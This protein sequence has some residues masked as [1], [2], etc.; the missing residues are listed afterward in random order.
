[1]KRRL[2]LTILLI[3]FVYPCFSQQSDWYTQGDFKPLV[4]LEYT[5][6]NPLST[7][8][9][10]SPVIIRRQDFPMPDIHEMWVTVVDPMLPSAPEPT[11]EQLDLQG[12]HE[13]RAESN[14]HIVF[15]QLD[16]IDKDGIWDELFFQ[17]DLKA[18]ESRKIYIYIGE[19]V[20]GWNPHKTHANIGS[21]CR[22][23]MPFWENENM[24][25]KIWFA[26][27]TDVFGKHEPILMSYKLYM[28]NIDGYGVSQIDQRYGSD[29]QRV[30]SSFGG[31]AICVFEEANNPEKPSMP[32]FT[33]THDKLAKKSLWNAGQISD[34]RYAYEVVTNG[35]VRSMIKIKGMNWN[36]GNGFY[37]YEQIYSIEANT[38]YTTAQV[39]FTKFFPAV[40]GVEMGC[41]IR[42]KPEQDNFFQKDGLVITSGPEDIRDPENIDE[43]K[44]WRVNFIG[45]A[46]AVKDS[47]SPKYQ[48]VPTNSK[49]HTF[50][51]KPNESK[52]Y[53]YMVM[54][55]WAEGTK[56]NTKESFNEYAKKNYVEYN[57]PVVSKFIELEKQNK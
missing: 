7:D 47:Y 26:N 40:A 2:L 34:T 24:G 37:E 21:Y 30:A 32:R 46:L 25:W 13:L 51:I 16:D 33:P 42:M 44:P 50:R 31:G 9:T 38:H 48:F 41:G 12:G 53:E 4:R 49:N 54:A 8:R 45:M 39:K 5:I 55:S 28:D 20:R 18:K 35:P 11:N 43:R 3:L 23:Q 6:S 57:N 22:H 17:M 27:C 10:S 14:G 15:H 36:S 29:V 19:N 52:F 1:M 56:Y